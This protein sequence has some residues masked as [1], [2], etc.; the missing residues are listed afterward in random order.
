MLRRRRIAGTRCTRARKAAFRIR[1]LSAVSSINSPAGCAAAWDIAVRPIFANCRSAAALCESLP[2]VCVKATFTTS[3]SPARRPTIRWNNPG[4]L[5]F[6]EWL[7]VVVWAGLIFTFS[8]DAFS[9]E[10]TQSVIVSVLHTLFPVAAEN[11]LLALHDFLRKCAH[12]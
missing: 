2:P 7:L 1:G 11:T 3:S 9:S 6:R 12:V 5:R 10:H 4:F 8:T